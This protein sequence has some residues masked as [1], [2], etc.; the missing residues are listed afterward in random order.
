MFVLKINVLDQSGASISTTLLVTLINFGENICHCSNIFYA[1]IVSI[2]SVVLCSNVVF[3]F[4]LL[5]NF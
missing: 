3:F 4:F 5:K 2:F 1:F